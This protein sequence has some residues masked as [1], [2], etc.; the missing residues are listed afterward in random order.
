MVL[1]G[2]VGK[3]R[4]GKDTVSDYLVKHHN[5]VKMAFAD[6]IKQ[7]AKIIFDFNDE[8][9]YGD[10]KEL[11][12]KK[13]G[14]KPRDVLQ[15]LGTEFGQYDLINYFPELKSKINRNI[16]VEKLKSD[17]Y[18]LPQNTNVIISD[19]RFKHEIDEIIKMGG[20]IIKINRNIN[21]TISDNHISENEMEYID[22][23]K[24][25]YLL[26]NNSSLENLYLLIDRLCRS[27]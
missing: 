5:F 26:E 3:K 17:Y 24:F 4:S 14:I 9:L 16:W 8:Q 1:I 7:I 10:D 11:L 25:N 21:N 2:I 23:S 22:H 6:P 13:W 19:T 15:K 20:I 27:L 12:D 18:K